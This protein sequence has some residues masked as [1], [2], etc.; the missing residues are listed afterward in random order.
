MLKLGG[1]FQG[2]VIAEFGLVERRVGFVSCW[3]YEKY[4][5]GAF[6]DRSI[7]PRQTLGTCRHAGYVHVRA[8]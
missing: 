7:E 6:W 1:E 8:L 4:V 5:N 3:K 2:V